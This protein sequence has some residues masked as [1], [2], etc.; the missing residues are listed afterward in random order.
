[1]S[2]VKDF[3][4]WLKKQIGSIYVL[5]AQGEV[6]FGTE[7]ISKM[8]KS[9]TNAERAIAFY[10][11]QRKSGIDP[12]AAY[13]CS[14]LIV[15]FLLDNKLIS[16]D[17]NAQGLYSKC[18]T[19]K[20]SELKAGD[21]VFHHNGTKIHHVGVYVGDNMVIHAKGRDYGVV[22]ENF[23]TN[24]W[25]RFGRY[26][27]LQEKESEVNEMP[28]KLKITN[29]LMRSD[30]ICEL[31]EALNRLGYACG[32]P[33]GV[34]G[35]NTIAGIEAFC[36]AHNAFQPAEMTVTVKADNVSYT[37]TVNKK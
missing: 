25:N 16:G 24:D 11:K 9:D 1:M 20:K 22:K 15:R 13:D 14:G 34:C 37:G 33:D 27:P 21:L 2:K 17:T 30:A 5:G 32:E 29:P 19:I 23:S 6:S 4:E 8:E 12:I 31:Q 28:I 35:K 36:K 10:E 26:E 3:I 18:K 7:W